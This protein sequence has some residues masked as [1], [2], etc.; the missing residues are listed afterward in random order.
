MHIVTPLPLYFPKAHTD[1]IIRAIESGIPVVSGTLTLGGASTPMTIAGSMIHGLATDFAAIVLGQLVRKGCF[2]MGASDIAFMDP[3]SGGLGG[4]AQ[5]WS[6]EG[7]VC[8]IMRSLDFPS[9]T[10]PAG[11]GGGRGLDQ[12]TVSQATATM[13]QTFYT[14]PATCDYLGLTDGGMTHSLPLLLFCH[15]LIGLLRTLWKGIAIDDETLA[16]ELARS[17][18]PCASYLGQHHTAKYCRI[19]PWQSRYRQNPMAAP[20]NGDGARDLRDPIDAHLAEIL[21]EHRCDP[22]PDPLRVELDAIL[23]KYEASPLT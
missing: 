15:D 12:R 19:E 16:L 2:C 8:Q 14:R 6:A 22:L 5:S 10:G 13:M 20:K 4:H 18:G 1:Q 7:A 23:A 21:A 17:Q 9:L 11:V 3:A